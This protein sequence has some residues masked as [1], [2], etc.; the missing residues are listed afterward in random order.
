MTRLKSLTAILLCTVLTAALF[1]NILFVRADYNPTVTVDTVTAAPGDSVLINI[2]ISDNTALMAITVTFHYDPNVLEYTKFHAGFL[3]D[4]LLQ[5]HNGYVSFVN[6]ESENRT[7]NGTL[8]TLEFKVK[9]D[10]QVGFYPI[11]IKNIWPGQ[12]ADNLTGCFACWEGTKI[13]PTV[14]AGGVEIKYNGKNCKHRYGKWTDTV[15]AKCTKGGMQ[16]RVCS[17]CGHNENRET[18]PVGHEFTSEW[19]V[20]RPATSEQD[21]IMSRHCIRCDKT[22]D[23]VTFSLLDSA[24]HDFSNKKDDAIQPETWQLLLEIKQQQEHSPNTAEEDEPQQTDPEEKPTSEEDPKLQEP[25]SA[26]Q[27]IEQEKTADLGFI[28]RTVQYFVGAHG[29]GGL[30]AV[31]REGVRTVMDQLR[32]K[33]ILPILSVLFLGW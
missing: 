27:L 8:V 25:M 4:Y 22:A 24:T 26:E 19:I 10:A 28:D 15:E 31:L 33:L 17:I 5:D 7:E 9:E 12:R 1:G 21:G 29:D 13:T 2:D 30:M 16:T 3:R 14:V 18:D 6:C 11:T 23:A 32:M 20:D